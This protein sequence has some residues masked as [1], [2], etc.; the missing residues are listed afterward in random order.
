VGLEALRE[1]YREAQQAIVLGSAMGKTEAVVHYNDLGVYRLLAPFRDTAELRSFYAETA[2]KLFAH[3][4]NSDL[5]LV[6]TLRLYFQND[7]K[8]TD[9]AAALFIHVNTLKY[10]LRRMET[11]TGYSLQR[12]EGKLMLHLGLKLA[13]MMGDDYR[14][15]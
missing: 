12:S 1:S 9:T 14:K 2:G 6:K 3:D 15:R 8:L 13:D 11:L 10:R 7:E 5:Q 4:E